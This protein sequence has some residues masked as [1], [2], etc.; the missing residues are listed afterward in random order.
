MMDLEMRKGYFQAIQ[1]RYFKAEKEEKGAILDEYCK[2]TGQNR[3]YVIRKLGVAYA[4][5]ALSF[6]KK[7]KP[8]YDRDVMVPLIKIWEILGHPCG[9]RLKPMVPEMIEILARC[10]EL[11]VPEPVARQLATMGSAT[12]DR[13]LKRQKEFL[14]KKRFSTTKPGYLLKKEIPIRL[15]EWDTRKVGYCEI[16]LVAHCGDSLYGEFIHTL[17]LVEIATGWTEQIAV[18]GKGQRNVFAALKQLR[19]RT[20]FT[21]LGIDSDNGS[22][23]INH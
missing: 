19:E 16:D 10:G 15:T 23:F 21:W 18:M 3:K 2:N 8:T 5:K 13:R 7:R 22:E 12:M 9:Q 14:H 6:R 11:A 17:D 4:V 1:R 20:P